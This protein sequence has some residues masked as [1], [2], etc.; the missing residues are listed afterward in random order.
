MAAAKRR[1][2]GEHSVSV[3]RDLSLVLSFALSV[4]GHP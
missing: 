3:A 2:S 1:N 4:I